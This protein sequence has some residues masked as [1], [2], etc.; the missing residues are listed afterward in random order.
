M[1]KCLFDTHNCMFMC[2]NCIY[3][4]TDSL[5]S[6]TIN[7]SIQIIRQIIYTRYCHFESRK[8]CEHKI[9]RKYLSCL[10][11]RIKLFNIY[12]K[13]C[14]IK[15][16][17]NDYKSPIIDMDIQKFKLTKSIR[18][19]CLTFTS[20][21]IIKPHLLQNLLELYCLHMDLNNLYRTL[22]KP[23]KIVY[24]NPNTE[25]VDVDFLMVIALTSND[26][27]NYPKWLTELLN[28]ITYSQNNYGYVYIRPILDEIEVS[29]LDNLL[30]IDL[31]EL[32]R[33]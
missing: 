33:S 8:I 16:I 9:V 21:H 13:N 29:W 6:I 14:N 17:P 5:I 32:K 19:L 28:E 7:R 4:Q 20:L 10:L 1:L 31:E 26:N 2:K 24:N 12:V 22:N 11:D 3:K 18:E 23:I 27:T 15:I 30:T 25:P